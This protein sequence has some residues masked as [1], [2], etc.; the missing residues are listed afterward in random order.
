MLRHAK[1]FGLCPEGVVVRLFVRKLWPTTDG[2][3]R[4]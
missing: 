4:T 1:S 2:L 3:V